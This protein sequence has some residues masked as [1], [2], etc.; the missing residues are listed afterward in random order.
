[1]LEAPSYSRSCSAHVQFSSNSYQMVPSFENIKICR[2]QFHYRSFQALILIPDPWQFLAMILTRFFPVVQCS[3]LG[4]FYIQISLEV[5]PRAFCAVVHSWKKLWEINQEKNI[6]GEYY[7]IK[8]NLIENSG[9][10]R[11]GIYYIGTFYRDPSRRI[12]REAILYCSS[13]RIFGKFVEK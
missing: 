8:S 3:I 6:R 9:N 11:H 4:P 2:T 1:M 5:Y 7:Q 12:H 10:V 13:S